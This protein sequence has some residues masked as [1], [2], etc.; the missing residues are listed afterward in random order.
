MSLNGGLPPPGALHPARADEKDETVSS[1]ENVQVQATSVRKRGR[2]RRSKVTTATQQQEQQLAALTLDDGEDDD[3]DRVAHPQ[4]QQQQQQQ[5]VQQQAPES[6]VLGVE[7]SSPLEQ[8]QGTIPWTPSARAS[9]V[10]GPSSN[11]QAAIATPETSDVEQQK[12][13][14]Q[15]KIED[16]KIA[17]LFAE[18]LLLEQDKYLV[19]WLSTTNMLAE[20]KKLV[21]SFKYTGAGAI[22]ATHRALET[23]VFNSTRL[24]LSKNAAK[25]VGRRVDAVRKIVEQKV[26]ALGMALQT[27]ADWPLGIFDARA[28]QHILEAVCCAMSKFDIAPT[29]TSKNTDGSAERNGCNA[30]EDM[31]RGDEDDEKLDDNDDDDGCVDDD[32]NVDVD[33]G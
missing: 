22:T 16:P 9:M 20:N 25:K 7:I 12:Q 6:S 15:Q 10:E 11:T 28:G 13:Q 21:L 31:D 32:W 33:E 4:Q 8:L 19:D 2:S 14:Q 29:I 3:E 1:L 30:I 5:R 27:P 18:L 26:A 24:A 17:A 23:A